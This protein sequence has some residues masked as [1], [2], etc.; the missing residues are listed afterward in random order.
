MELGSTDRRAGDG[1]ELRERER[2]REKCVEQIG[3]NRQR[4]TA[5]RV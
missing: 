5:V 2:E 4:Q 3:V 1:R